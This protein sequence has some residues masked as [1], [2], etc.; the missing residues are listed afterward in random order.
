MKFLLG[1]ILGIILVLA[2]IWYAAQRHNTTAEDAKSR[3]ES[4]ATGAK[5]TVQTNWKNLRTDDIRE[6]LARNG[7]VVRDKAQDVGLSVANATA[8]ARITAAIKGKL[9]TNRD[10]S[11]ISI[12]VNTTAGRVT[13]S[14]T[15]SDP[16]KIREAMQLALDTDGVQEVVSTLQ[17][18]P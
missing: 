5:E 11:A 17:V 13:L 15:V 4:V 18:K 2:L 9:L 7:R 6:E 16:D 1:L 8:D 10:L 12:S 14:G 3:I